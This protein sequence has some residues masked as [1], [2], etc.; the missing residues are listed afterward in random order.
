MSRRL[1]VLNME[2][3]GMNK[4][5]LSGLRSKGWSLIAVEIPYPKIC[6]WL[7]MAI[8]FNPNISLWKKQFEV[9]LG[10]LY[11]TPWVFKW[12]TSFCDSVTK[13]HKEEFDVMLQ[14]SGLFAPSRNYSRISKPYA[15]FNDY[16]L[17]LCDKYSDWA[18]LPFF[19]KRLHELEKC[20]QE[21]ASIVFATS[22]NTRKSFIENYGVNERNVINVGYGAPMEDVPEFNKEY[23][24]KTILFIGKDFKR[25]GGYVLLEAFL[26]VRKVIQD[27]RLIIVGPNDNTLNIKM[28]G[29]DVLGHVKDRGAI[30][31]LYKNASIFVMPSFCEP[32]GLVFLEAMLYK[33]PCIG[34]TID[35]IPEVIDDGNTG[36]L[37]PANNVDVLAERILHL[38]K[39]KDIM[40]RMGI[41][42]R[43][44][45][46]KDFG[47]DRVI[48]MVDCELKS[49]SG[50]K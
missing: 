19:K 12:R 24:G 37:V 23:D 38:L 36:F 41:A 33:L 39:N 48:D 47:W 20:L 29:V 1:L 7:A 22:E 50:E 8:A 6:R 27:A 5:L 32:F 2:V 26:K 15:T 25:K 18:P 16:T 30:D 35:A 17:S 43:R 14:I 34:T 44:K 21:K 4:Y 13:K 45:L 49:I 9:T 10:K 31:D 46:E 3:S 42:G 40:T 28:A 11:K